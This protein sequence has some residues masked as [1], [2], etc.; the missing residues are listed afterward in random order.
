M[1]SSPGSTVVW[2]IETFSGASLK[3]C[4]A[5][6]YAMHAST[7]VHFVCFAVDG[8]EVQTWR[9]GDPVPQAFAAPVGYRFISHNW[10]FE[11]AI[12]RH[13]LIPR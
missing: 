5:H 8:G 3:D 13:V 7:G 12:L 6:I 11:N 4:G 2:D 1:R 10:T 9:P